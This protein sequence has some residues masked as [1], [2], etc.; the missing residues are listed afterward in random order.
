MPHLRQACNDTL[1]S[2]WDDGE[3]G[4]KQFLEAVWR[5]YLMLQK[6]F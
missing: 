5:R 1:D 4:E 6:G 2:A 3:T